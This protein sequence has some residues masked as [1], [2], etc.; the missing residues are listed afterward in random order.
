MRIYSFILSLLFQFLFSQE[1]INRDY[2]QYDIIIKYSDDFDNDNIK[3]VLYVLHPQKKKEDDEVTKVKLVI[4]KGLKKKSFIKI[5]DD[6]NIFP[7]NECLGKSDNYISDLSFKHNLLSYTTSVA[8]LASD[9]YIVIKFILEFL[10]DSFIVYE[11]NVQY[12]S[13]EN[14]N[15]V[16]ISLTKNDFFT[17]KFNYYNWEIDNAWMKYLNINDKNFMKI[18]KMAHKIKSIQP[19]LSSQ[20]LQK[21]RYRRKK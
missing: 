6:D 5:Y 7:C 21:L 11:Y 16:S 3:D 15:S 4:Y 18:R 12:L 20:I 2:P 9:G 1:D 13:V 19:N 14:Y 10:K 17:T 8:P